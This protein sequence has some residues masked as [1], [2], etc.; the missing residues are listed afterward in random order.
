MFVFKT[1]KYKKKERTIPDEMEGIIL[2]DQEI[3]DEY[4][5]APRLYGGITLTNDEQSILELPPKYAIHEKV[6]KEHCET[7]NHRMRNGREPRQAT[8]TVDFPKHIK[9][10]YDNKKEDAGRGSTHSTSSTTGNAH[11]RF[12]G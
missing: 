10:R 3:G 6:D 1:S 12:C 11:I 4:T 7:K 8:S 5:S 9:D 2:K